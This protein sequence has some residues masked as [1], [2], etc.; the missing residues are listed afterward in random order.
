LLR[1]SGKSLGAQVYVWG[2]VGSFPDETCL[3][4]YQAIANHESGY[5][6]SGLMGAKLD[7]VIFQEKEGRKIVREVQVVRKDRIDATI[8]RIY[9]DDGNVNTRQ[10]HWGDESAK[11]QTITHFRYD[12]QGN[13]LQI[14]QTRKVF[15][16]DTT[17][18]SDLFSYTPDGLLRQAQHFKR[19][20]QDA[21][22]LLY[23]DFF[24]S[25]LAGA[26]PAAPGNAQPGA[27]TS[28]H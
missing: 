9:G 7:K 19:V 22:V 6:D 20:N 4:I 18:D 8:P 28:S 26:T 14:L 16:G 11:L 10:F 24:S 27:S 5:V 21:D 17:T 15:N 13:L 12:A 23:V 2:P 3:E 25:N 1:T